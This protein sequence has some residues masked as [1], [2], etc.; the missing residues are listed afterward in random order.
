MYRCNI[1]SVTQAVPDV[2][3][4]SWLLALGTLGMAISLKNFRNSLFFPSIVSF[5]FP[6]FSSLFR[7]SF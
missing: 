3:F 5:F 2:F 7:Q 6:L 4:L 1:R